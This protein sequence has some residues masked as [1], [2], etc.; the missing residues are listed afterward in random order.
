LRRHFPAAR[1]RHCSYGHFGE[2][3]YFGKSLL[4]WRLVMLGAR[5]TPEFMAPTWLIFMQKR[6]VKS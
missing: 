1:F 3:R 5:M 6:E 4:L 2:P